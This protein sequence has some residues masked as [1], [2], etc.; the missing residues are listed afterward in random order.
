MKIAKRVPTE[1][2]KSRLGLILNFALNQT[3]LYQV[4]FFLQKFGN[5]LTILWLMID[6]W[7]PFLL[8]FGQL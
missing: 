3:S 7:N 6:G 4:N 5:P 1:N 2:S 8:L